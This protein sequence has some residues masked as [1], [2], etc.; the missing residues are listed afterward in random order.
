MQHIATRRSGNLVFTRDEA[1]SGGHAGVQLC[2]V[3][4]RLP[5]AKGQQRLGGLALTER[6][7]ASEA[8]NC[9]SALRRQWML[10]PSID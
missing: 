10:L 2:N 4:A 3:W 8:E 6:A 7:R 9:L 5:E 1:S